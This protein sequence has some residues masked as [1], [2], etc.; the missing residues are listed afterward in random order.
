[1]N[2]TKIKDELE[3]IVGEKNVF[4][5]LAER[6]PYRYGN[7]VE[8]RIEEPKFLPDFVVKPSSSK[9]ISEIL[10]L[11]NR[12]KISV[13]PWGGGTDLTGA[14]S[15]IK[16]GIIIDMKNL[17]KIEI[18]REEQYVKSGAGAILLR[19][20]EEAERDGFLFPHE[21]TTQ[22]SATLGGAI[23]TNSFGHRSGPYRHIRNL[24]LG[25]EVVLPTGEVIKTKPLFKT[26]MGYDLISLFVGSEGTLGIITEAT[27]K[28]IPE[29][30]A[31]EISFYLFNSFEDGLESAKEIYTNVTPEFFDLIELSFLKY[32]ENSIK[33]LKK[34]MD[35]K[36]VSRYLHSKY[37]EESL[38]GKILGSILPKLPPTN[39][40]ISYLESTIKKKECIS[41]LTVGFEGDKEGVRARTNI[42]NRVAKSGDGVKFENETFYEKRFTSYH[43]LFEDILYHLPTSPEE[44]GIMTLDVSIPI[45]KVN[46]IKNKIHD[47]VQ[48]YKKIHLLDIDLYSSLST[49]G[50]DLAIPLDKSKIHLEFFKE[51][52]NLVLKADGSM[53]FA[54][55]VG[56]KLLPHLED[57]LSEGE[58]TAMKKIKRVFDPNNIMNPG[59]LG[60]TT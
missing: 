20:T 12:F 32:S 8:Y 11:A 49:L 29:P 39:K 13:I 41:I 6:L 5:E 36:I 4:T 53:S 1:M 52:K 28:L 58:I 40:I 45:T 15:P 51:L 43:E 16:G 33:F 26:S 48:R 22:P 60:D 47:L 3:K 19:I 24:I 37:V 10:K 57:E 9:Q 27:M 30:E 21:I 38:Y 31:R 7:V 35:S 44:Q 34:Y 46:E 2:K 18:N 55:G 50:I 56:T 23:A 17:N 59:K 54:H 42:V 14:N 25:I